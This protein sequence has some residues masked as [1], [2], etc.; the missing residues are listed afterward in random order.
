MK[1]KG[2]IIIGIFLI[3]GII[4]G[5][6]AQDSNDCGSGQCVLNGECYDTYERSPDNS[7]QECI[8]GQWQQ[9]IDC[10]ASLGQGIPAQ[11]SCTDNQIIMKLSDQTNAHGGIASSDRHEIKV[12]YNSIFNSQYSG[13]SNNVCVRDSNNNTINRVLILSDDDNAHAKIPELSLEEG[14]AEVCFGNLVCRASNSSCVSGEKRIVSISKSSDAHISLEA[15]AEYDY[16]ICCSAVPG[17]GSLTLSII[18]PQNWQ[19]FTLDDNILFEV[20]TPSL[21]EMGSDIDIEYDFGDGNITK[22]ENCLSGG[23]CNIYHKYSKQAH[24]TIIV[25]AVKKSNNQIVTKHVD[26]LVHKNGLNLFAI[27]SQPGFGENIPPGDITP[28]S[29]SNAATPPIGKP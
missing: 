11:S 1:E 2:F 26:I 25:K 13:G 14:D 6:I 23:K 10:G 9:V 3:L 16:N 29:R 19:N 7:C 17:N 5:V 15:N 28:F 24:Y 12:C 8:S 18:K 4:G 21:Q 27:I 22:I 20:Q